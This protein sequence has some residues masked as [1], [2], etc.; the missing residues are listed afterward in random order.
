M[1]KVHQIFTHNSL[2]NFNYIIEYADNKAIIIDPYDA[3]QLLKIL[4]DKNLELVHIINTHEHFD[5]TAGNDS[6]KAKTNATILAHY[7]ARDKIKGVDKF[8]NKGDKIELTDKN[9]LEVMD[10]PGHT[11][12]HLC[13][14]L[15]EN[16]LVRAVFTGDTLFNAGV[17][18]CHNNGDSEKL[19][20][21]IM[22]QFETLPDEVL[23]YPGHE[24]LEN[25]CNFTLNYEK[26]N[27]FANEIIKEYKK[28]LEEGIY[29]VSTIA[30]EKKINL[31]F[32]C[33]EDSVK[34]SL[35]IDDKKELF[36]KL[37]ELRNSW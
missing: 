7:N 33:E 30:V 3:G 21:T 10:T 35:G 22:R 1:V 4:Q 13:L 8:L 37:R 16:D 2:R 14:K 34:N 11:F 17:G 27:K 6:L 29:Y 19:F 26:E 15:V 12:A 5:H 28:L 25:N 24:Y 31:F 18:N 36:L 23:I 32:R 20:E 9:Y